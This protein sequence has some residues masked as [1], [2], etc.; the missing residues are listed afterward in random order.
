[1]SVVG[2]L[3]LVRHGQSLAN[4]AFPA[5]D[6]RGLLEAEV[7]GRDAEVPLTDIGEAQAAAVG[8]WL[9]A[10]APEQLPQIVITSPYLRARETWRI[11]AETAGLD[12]PKPVTD[13]RLVDRLLGELEMLTR[14]AVA[15][16]FPGE[17]D[18]R[19]EAG[20]YRY[21]PPGGESFADVEARLA[22]FL[23]DLN[24]K[25]AGERVV[26]V[27]HDAV[28]LMMR[29]VIQNLRWDEVIEMERAEG[30][31]RN[32]SISQ[33]LERAGHLE[34]VRYNFVDHLPSL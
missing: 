2:E 10:L 34:L 7:S 15:Q 26:V 12:L 24:R 11:A 8:S 30:T 29:A 17:A 19:A 23:L 16:R 21:A 3:I 9:A 27:A 5:A 22:A 1:M 14:A 4:V 32:A 28:V 25:H 20:E 33:F 13:D 18:R 31:V 6:E